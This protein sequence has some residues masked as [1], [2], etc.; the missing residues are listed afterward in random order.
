MVYEHMITFEK[1]QLIMIK[2]THYNFMID[3]RNCFDQTVKNG[4]WTKDN[5][6]EIATGQS[7]DYTTVCLL[8]YP[9]FEQYYVLIW[10]DLIKQQKLNANPEEMQQT[11]F[12]V[13]L[14]RA[15]NTQMFS[16]IGEAKEIVLDFSKWTK[17]ILKFSF[18][19][20]Q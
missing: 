20:I 4:L 19:L 16:I 10:I 6:S 17:K 5:I 14:D 3:G 13:N 11:S 9:Y 1:L 18:F 8:D 2:T 15:R 12:T 7:N